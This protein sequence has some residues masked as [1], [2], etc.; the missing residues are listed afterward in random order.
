[1]ID[2][3][4]PP[5]EFVKPWTKRDGVVVAIVIAC[6]V[7]SACGAPPSIKVSREAFEDEGNLWPLSVRRGEV[8]CV[9]ASDVSQ[10]AALWFGTE[11]GK[12][13]AL[14]DAAE[15]QSGFDNITALMPQ[16]LRPEV[17]VTPNPEAKARFQASLADLRSAAMEGCA[18]V[19]PA[20]GA[21]S[22]G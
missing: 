14:N 20:T 19:E 1:M 7:I 4:A 2:Q 16:D 10:P 6:S 9:P 11:D 13:F 15:G 8:G 3:N 22:G 21:A 18:S 5:T 12:V 17:G